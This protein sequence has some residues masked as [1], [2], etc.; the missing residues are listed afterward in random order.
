MPLEKLDISTRK[1]ERKDFSEVAELFPIRRCIKN[2]PS[3]FLKNETYFLK[4][5]LED[6][7]GFKDVHQKNHF[8]C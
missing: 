2:A 6:S 1:K 7:F 4:F 8:T 5:P 3:F